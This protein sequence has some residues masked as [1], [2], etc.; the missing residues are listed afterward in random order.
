MAIPLCSSALR[1]LSLLV[2]A[3]VYSSAQTLYPHDESP[4][5]VKRF[6]FDLNTVP[7][8]G[9]TDMIEL[10][11]LRSFPHLLIP[12]QAGTFSI[13]TS[14]LAMRSTNTPAIIVFTFEPANYSASFLPFIGPNA[15]IEWDSRATVTYITDL[16]V[17]Y[18]QQSTFLARI[19]GVV[20]ANYIKWVEDYVRRNP[21]FIPFSICSNA[22]SLSCFTKSHTWDTFIADRFLLSSSCHNAT[23]PTII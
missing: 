1:T 17:M 13:Q 6:L 3:L 8:V 22:D 4:I 7:K 15:T 16:N 10:Y 21:F 5:K 19:N 23:M 20:Y 14:G 11:H 18:W 9:D 12:S 2:L